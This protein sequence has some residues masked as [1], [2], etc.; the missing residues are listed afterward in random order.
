M[1]EDSRFKGIKLTKQRILVL[2]LL[3]QTQMPL[4]AQEIF[5]QI[6]TGEI[7]LSTI[8]RTLDLFV[9]RKII[10]KTNIVID[11]VSV[12]YYELNTN[13]HKHY[14]ICTSCN[15]LI[16]MKNCPMHDFQPIL[17]DQDFEVAGHKIEIYGTCKRCRLN[18]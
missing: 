7:Y 6:N 14:A 15:K 11:N 2:E 8:Y 10:S 4:S 16:A 5:Q 12:A 13:T 9:E 18:K 3:E 1:L 17:D